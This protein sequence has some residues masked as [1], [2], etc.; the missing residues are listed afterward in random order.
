MKS[1]PDNRLVTGELERRWEA[2]LRELQ[3]AEESLARDQQR[4]P[5]YIIP[6]DLLEMLRDIGPRLP[7]L[8]NDGLLQTAQKKSLLRSLIDKVVIHRLAPDQIQLRVVWRGGATTEKT[9]HREC[10]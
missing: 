6:A 8:W 5:T 2:S 1:D 3:A 4:A 10:R 9:V 7:E